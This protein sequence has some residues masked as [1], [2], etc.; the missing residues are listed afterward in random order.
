[1]GSSGSRDHLDIDIWFDRGSGLLRG[2]HE[3]FTYER[4]RGL[5]DEG[6]N[7]RG[8]LVGLKFLVRVLAG[9]GAAA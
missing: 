3:D 8:D 7:H 4:L 2:A 5:R 9:G 6:G 1:M